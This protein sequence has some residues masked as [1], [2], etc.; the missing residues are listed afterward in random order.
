MSR[1]LIY[2]DNFKYIGQEIESMDMCKWLIDGVCCNDKCDCLGDYPYP[3]EMCDMFCDDYIACNYF[4]K[5]DG[6]VEEDKQ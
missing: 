3:S 1:T 5:E 4:E 2:D 6:I